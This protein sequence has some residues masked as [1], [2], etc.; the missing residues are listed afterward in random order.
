M[1][2]KLIKVLLLASDIYIYQNA[3]CNDK[4][5]IRVIHNQFLLGYFT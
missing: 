3:L 1:F 2:F 4:E 5:I